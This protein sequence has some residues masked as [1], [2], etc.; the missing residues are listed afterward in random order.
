MANKAHET[1]LAVR[2][3]IRNFDAYG[4]GAPA[5]R[6]SQ[7]ANRHV[8]CLVSDPAA[9]RFSLFGAVW[10]SLPATD[11][12]GKIRQYQAFMN[13]LIAML[14]AEGVEFGP[15]RNRATWDLNALDAWQA[16]N[17]THQAAMTMLNTAIRALVVRAP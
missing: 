13:I 9:T 16:R 7:L 5:S 14:Q 10:R 17:P 2:A 11:E 15:R 6:Y 3:L 4:S 8:P 1:F 12:P